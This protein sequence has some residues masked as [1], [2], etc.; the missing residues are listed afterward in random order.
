MNTISKTISL[1][2]ILAAGALPAPAH[3]GY[4]DLFEHADYR[5]GAF[6]L[7]AN[8]G[9]HSLADYWLDEWDDWND[10]ISSVAVYGSVQV[11]LYE[12][13]NYLG[14]YLDLTST[15]RDLRS[16]AFEEWNDR[17]SSLWVF[18]YPVYGWYYDDTLQSY[19]YWDG[20]WCYHENGLGWVW[21]GY[22]DRIEQT[23]WLYDYDLGYLYTDDGF[24][25]W[26]WSE[27]GHMY[28]Y[29]VFSYNPRYFWNGTT[30]FPSYAN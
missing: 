12:H 4:V 7:Y 16:H 9:I 10:V 20:D 17:V 27:H 30:W 26:F 21:A 11:R 5:G 8:E 22:Y 1:V 23:G 18:E 25:P 13:A 2:T 15:V 29:Y 19:L 6:R 3:T 14:R 28:Y 24:Y